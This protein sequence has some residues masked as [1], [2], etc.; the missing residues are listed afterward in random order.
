MLSPGDVAFADDLALCV[1]LSGSTFAW[2]GLKRRHIIFDYPTISRFD[3]R[4]RAA[5]AAGAL[6]LLLM[7]GAFV[8]LIAFW[9]H[10]FSLCQS[11]LSCTLRTAVLPA[12]ENGEVIFLLLGL[13]WLGVWFWRVRGPDGHLRLRVGPGTYHDEGELAQQVQRALADAGQPPID[14]ELLIRITRALRFRMTAVVV[15]RKASAYIEQGQLNVPRYVESVVNSP[16]GAPF[17]LSQAQLR[18]VLTAIVTYYAEVDTQV[19]QRRQAMQSRQQS[20]RRGFTNA[21]G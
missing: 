13:L 21:R 3:L 2:D 14:D 6:A 10:Y 4:G 12:V 8:S 20:R 18:L 19:R 11:S 16:F 5:M 15:Q 7:L 17:P 1:I 9:R